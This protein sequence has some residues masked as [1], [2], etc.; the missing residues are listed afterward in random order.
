M[1]NSADIAEEIEALATHCRPPIMT[2][3]NR[4]LWLRDWCLDLAGFDIEAIRAAFRKVRHSGAAKFPTP[5]QVIGMI[6]Q[7]QP[8]VRAPKVEPWRPLSDAEYDALGLPDKIRHR[9]V[10]AAEARSEAVRL[11]VREGWDRNVA[12]APACYREQMRI[13]D[14]HEDE[15]KRLRSYL[16]RQAAA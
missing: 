3:E 6:R 4:A 7:S 2:T 16:K 15:A 8:E 9:L 5:G 1:A 11:A 10:L 14:G 13:A 12:D